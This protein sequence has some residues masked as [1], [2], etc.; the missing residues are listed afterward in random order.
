MTD[1]SEDQ[2]YRELGEA[3]HPYVESQLKHALTRPSF[4]RLL[5]AKARRASAPPITLPR[6]T[7]TAV[8][9]YQAI[10]SMRT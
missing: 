2:P 9:V 3:L 8:A 1:S 7:Q 5:G 10:Q 6:L 4:G